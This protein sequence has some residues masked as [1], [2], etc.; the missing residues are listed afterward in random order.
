MI[1]IDEVYK[2]REVY[3]WD[4]EKIEKQI[5][6]LIEERFLAFNAGK[7]FNEQEIRIEFTNELVRL[8]NEY[9]AERKNIDVFYLFHVVFDSLF[10]EYLPYNTSKSV[11]CFACST[12]DQSGEF[13]NFI[14]YK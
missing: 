11:L 7:A 8:N 5:R 13:I 12:R 3:K 1:K 6:K 2:R 9:E 4:I 14:G 10:C